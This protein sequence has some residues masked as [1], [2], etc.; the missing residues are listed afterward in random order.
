M[1]DTYVPFLRLF[2]QHAR[3]NTVQLFGCGPALVEELERHGLGR[4]N[5]CVQA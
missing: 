3:S 4:R 5:S 1:L 2:A